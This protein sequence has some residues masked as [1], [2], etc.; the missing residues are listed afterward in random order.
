MFLLALT[1][2]TLSGQQTRAVQ[3]VSRVP[4]VTFLDVVGAPSNVQ[5]IRDG[6][7]SVLRLRLAQG[8]IRIPLVL[9]TN[10]DYRLLVQ[11]SAAVEISAPGVRPFAGTERMTP[12]ALNVSLA[13]L[14]SVNSVPRTILQGPRISSGGNNSTPNN[15]LLVELEAT[16]PMDA[17]MT[18][19]IE[20][21]AQ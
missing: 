5:I 14:G 19:W 17:E 3:I 9:R 13:E 18:V 2:G 16:V 4:K 12:G 11:S 6:E 7:H 15:A 10:T 20:P 8:N 21:A 1:A